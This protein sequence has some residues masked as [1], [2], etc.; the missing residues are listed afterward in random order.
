M[1]GNLL[2]LTRGS[3]SKKPPALLELKQKGH[4]LIDA[5][6][7]SGLSR[8]RVYNRLR[9]K[10]NRPWGKEHFAN[11]NSMSEAQEAVDSLAH[12]LAER[13][14]SQELEKQ[15]PKVETLPWPEQQRLIREMRA[16]PRTFPA[17]SRWSKAKRALKILLS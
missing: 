12:W 2:E 14:H 15:A 7:I 11:M 17:E 8:T 5:L 3:V 4:D 13:T 6:V 10:L 1:T 16:T 9:K